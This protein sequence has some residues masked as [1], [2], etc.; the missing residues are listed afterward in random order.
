MGAQPVVVGPRLIGDARAMALAL[1]GEKLAAYVKD[2]LVPLHKEVLAELQARSIDEGRKAESDHLLTFMGSITTNIK[3][4]RA[5]LAA[6]TPAALPV[7]VVKALGKA[8]I[9]A[10]AELAEISP[11]P[12]SF[13]ER[14]SDLRQSAGNLFSGIGKA[15]GNVA[16]TIFSRPVRQAAAG[17]LL[18]TAV[19]TA[20]NADTTS[21]Q[22][23]T[24]AKATHT[25]KADA[26]QRFASGTLTVAGATAVSTAAPVY[27]AALAET[28]TPVAVKAAF[29]VA[30]PVARQ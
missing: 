22:P 29:A 18:G 28:T 19:S 9:T 2:T 6:T 13:R 20:H 15:L 30:E 16:D 25:I 24:A 1:T 7:D 4:A 8:S 27:T 11:P 26:P 23:D 17:I 21:P 12:K 10:R 14:F 5:T 3:Q